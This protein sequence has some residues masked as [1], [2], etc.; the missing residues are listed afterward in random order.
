[1]KYFVENNYQ[2]TKRLGNLKQKRKAQ[3]ELNRKYEQKSS[4]VST[5]FFINSARN[6]FEITPSG[7]IKSVFVFRVVFFF[8]LGQVDSVE[9]SNRV[10]V[11]STKGFR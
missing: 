3:K 2:R 9:D 1:M 6:F 5:G 4:I 8:T 7:L 10:K 11:I